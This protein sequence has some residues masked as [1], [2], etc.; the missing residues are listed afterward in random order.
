MNPEGVESFAVLAQMP[1]GFQGTTPLSESCVEIN[2]HFAV[3]QGAVNSNQSN[4]PYLIMLDENIDTVWTWG[5]DWPMGEGEN[6]G[7]DCLT[8][9]NN[10]NLLVVSLARFGYF[11]G[12]DSPDSIGYRITQLDIDGAVV[13]NHLNILPE[14]EYCSEFSFSGARQIDDF[15]LMWGYTYA[16]C[17]TGDRQNFFLKTDLTGEILD[18]YYFGNPDNCMDWR[19]AATITPENH[20]VF[21]YPRCID[22]DIDTNIHHQQ[23]IVEFDPVAW[24]LISDE[25]LD[26]SDWNV[27]ISVGN[28]ES[29]I[30]S[31][32]AH[33]LQ[34]ATCIIPLMI[35]QLLHQSVQSEN[36]WRIRMAL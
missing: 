2:G 29:M 25:T 12:G 9:L 11:A 5:A 7:P 27:H 35:F 17:G 32:M 28:N 3:L 30:Q 4:Y 16:E 33:L 31:L 23:Q 8:Q 20:I 10:G 14:S 26:I 34:Q 21:T 24:Q 19:G 1:I 13:S 18:V 6:F 22:D 36:E 15:L